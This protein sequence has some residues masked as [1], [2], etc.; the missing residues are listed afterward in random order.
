MKVL[1]VLAQDCNNTSQCLTDGSVSENPS[2]VTGK[3]RP[4]LTLLLL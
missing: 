4:L 3:P 1:L 2:P